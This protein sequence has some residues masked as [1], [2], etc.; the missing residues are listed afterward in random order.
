MIKLPLSKRKCLINK[1]QQEKQKNPSRPARGMYIIVS[2]R[3]TL[4]RTRRQESSH[5]SRSC[6]P[7]LGRREGGRATQTLGK[8]KLKK[9][10]GSSCDFP[11][12]KQN[13]PNSTD[14][15]V[16]RFHAVLNFFRTA[17]RLAVRTDSGRK[18]KARGRRR[19]SRYTCVCAH[20]CV[21]M[22]IYIYNINALCIL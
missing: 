22:S 10:L 12:D 13:C 14:V 2:R 17:H 1:Q 6:P 15:T 3:K 20:I 16:P 11:V 9:I 7:L 21:S 19:R 4:H 8:K 18:F 5:V